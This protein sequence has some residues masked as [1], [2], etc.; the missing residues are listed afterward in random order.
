LRWLRP[1]PSLTPW[2]VA[3]VLPVLAAVFG[4]MHVLDVAVRGGLE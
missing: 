3:G 4:A 2:V 1:P